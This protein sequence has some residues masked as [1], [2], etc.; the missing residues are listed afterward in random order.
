MR[1]N[2]LA[3]EIEEIEETLTRPRFLHIFAELLVHDRR[4]EIDGT[5]CPCCRSF[6]AEI[7]ERRVAADLVIDCVTGDRIH[8]ADVTPAEWA[9][10]LTLAERHDIP[11]RC[12]TKTL[13]LLL[14]D[15]GRHYLASGGHRA[16]KTSTGLVFFALQI[17]KFGGLERRC[18]LVGST[19]AKAFRLLAKIFRVTPSPSGGVVPAILPAALIARGP[20]SHR[21][22]DLETVLVDGTIIDLRSFKNDPGA[23][24]LKSDPIFAGLV[25]EAAHIYEASLSALMGRCVDLKGRLWLA[26]TATPSSALMP[27]VE[28]LQAWRRMAADDPIRLSGEHEGA[29][30]IFAALPMVDNPWI[31]LANIQHQLRTVDMAKPE[32]RRDYLGEFVASEGLCWP[33]FTTEMH[34][35]AHEARHVSKLSPRVLAEHRA[36]G[37]VNIT[38]RVA[39]GLFGRTNPHVRMAKASN[40]EFIIGQDV[41]MSPMSS[42]LLQITAPEDALDDRDA[43]HYWVIDTV[44]TPTSNSLAHAER[45]VSTP[46]ARVIDPTGSGSPLRGCGV[47][48]DATAIGKDPTARAHGQSGSVVETFWRAGLDCRAPMYVPRAS[49]PGKP[50]HRNPDLV[51]CFRLIHRL[52]DDGRFH[53]FARAGDLTNSFAVQLVTPD[54]VVPM[55][56]RRGKWDAIMG[57]IDAMRYAVWASANV[58][59]PAVARDWSSLPAA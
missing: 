21:A 37:H 24:R 51:D 45:L 12:T 18:W 10:F 22:S 6:H 28:K 11:L 23:E 57:P 36:A 31:E 15:T 47:I 17:L 8:E 5:R 42:C 32:N 30:W 58:Q 35:V 44:S 43:W 16:M 41:N 29:A 25:D 39:R 26:S 27:L 4:P 14:D 19:D 40:F 54:G 53:V 9:E 38:P 13:P 55:D 34:V 48:V 46:L 56:A 7:I 59:G 1:R 2:R 52:I 49:A 33:N 20:D 50:G 3:Q